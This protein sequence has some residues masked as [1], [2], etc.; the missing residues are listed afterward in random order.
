[1][2][3]LPPHDHT[4]AAATCWV[5]RL[6]CWP[7][8]GNKHARPA[9]CV[10]KMMLTMARHTLPRVRCAARPSHERL[11]HAETPAVPHSR[12]LQCT[13]NPVCKTF[14]TCWTQNHAATPGGSRIN[15]KTC[16]LPLGGAAAAAAST[17]DKTPQKHGAFLQSA[18]RIAHPMLTTPQA[19]STVCVKYAPVRRILLSKGGAHTIRIR[20]KCM[21]SLL[22]APVRH[23]TRRPSP[24]WCVVWGLTPHPNAVTLCLQCQR[25][26]TCVSTSVLK[27]QSTPP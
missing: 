21:Q 3:T 20:I 9:G 22:A 12:G 10:C 6:L 19:P 15:S 25:V 17:A 16:R 18:C 7:A 26:H 13:E 24:T 11:R 1:M 27:T 14:T 8:A 2:G 23:T 5:C 4:P